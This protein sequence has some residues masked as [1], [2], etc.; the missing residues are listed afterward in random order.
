[1]KGKL[2]SIT[3]IHDNS[4]IFVLKDLQLKHVVM[5]AFNLNKEILKYALI[6]AVLNSPT[7]ETV[8][9]TFQLWRESY[10]H[11]LSTYGRKGLSR[12][13][14]TQQRVLHGRPELRLNTFQK[15]VCCLALKTI[16]KPNA[17]FLSL[18]WL[19]LL[20]AFSFLPLASL[21]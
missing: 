16:K 7:R 8:T 10:L 3:L 21:F 4:T 2:Y 6:A 1:M 18:P 19:L 9:F 11:G 17:M 13:T 5:E 14:L 15:T 20:L 12:V